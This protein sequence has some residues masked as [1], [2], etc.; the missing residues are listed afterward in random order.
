MGG[1]IGGMGGAG[2][3]GATTGTG[4][5]SA[6]TARPKHWHESKSFGTNTQGGLA[7]QVCKVTTLNNSGTGSFKECVSGS[8][9]LVVFEVGGVIDLNGSPISVG[10]S[11]I[12]IA[13]QTAPSPGITLIRGNFTVSGSH[14]VVSHIAIQLGK[15]TKTTD[16]SNITGSNV[17]YDHVSA[18]WGTD[19]TLSLHGVNNVTLFKCVIAESLQFSGHTDGEHSKGS[20][21]NNGPKKLGIIGTL[22]AN[23]AARNPRVDG[24]EIFLANHVVHNWAPAW[25]EPAGS[26]AKVFNEAEL[27]NCTKCFNK[28]VK[29]RSGCNASL[30]NSV[31]FRGPDNM[32]GQFFIS[33]HAGRGNVYVK[34]DIIIDQAGNPLTVVNPAELT[35]LSAPPLWP[36]GFEPVPTEEGFYEVL[37]TAGPRPGDRDLHHARVIRQVADADTGKSEIIN[38]QDDVGGY[39]KSPAT[40]RAISSIPDGA[41]ARQAWLDELEDQ[42][43]VDRSVDLSRLYGLVGSAASDRLK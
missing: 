32:T 22:Y 19:E 17:V 3:G 18:W 35:V 27:A 39:P 9:K 24:G 40:T 12:T 30:V 1:A 13:G 6:S 41:I 16:A 10:G 26:D 21:I 15:T 38:S 8:N 37:R 43:A 31:A 5:G 4:G 28:A 29:I 23:N 25:D 33:G 20:L 14:V 42:I 7:G 34:D 36:E 2:K 11:N